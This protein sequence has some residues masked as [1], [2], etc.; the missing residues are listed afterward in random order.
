MKYRT[1]IVLVLLGILGI[2][3]SAGLGWMVQNTLSEKTALQSA[4]P[5]AGYDLAPDGKQTK[6]LMKNE[7]SNSNPV[8]ASVDANGKVHVQS[9][10]APQAGKS[11][12]VAH[13]QGAAKWDD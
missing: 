3:M 13:N 7:P 2:V 1:Q 11:D 10:P 8:I 12:Y 6:K 4:S 5:D 9:G